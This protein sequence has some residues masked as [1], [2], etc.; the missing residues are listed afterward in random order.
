MRKVVASLF[1]SL[2]GVAEFPNQWLFEFDDMM[3]A[4]FAEIVG[5][6]TILLGRVTYQP[7]RKA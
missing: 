1:V 2:D 4:I 6:D 3:A 5:F 7:E